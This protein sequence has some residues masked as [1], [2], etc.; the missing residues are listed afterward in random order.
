MVR[1]RV[2][3]VEDAVDGELVA[4]QD[5]DRCADVEGQAEEDAVAAVVVQFRFGARGDDGA[6]DL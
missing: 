2:G 6:V 3:V 5:V 4:M 1:G